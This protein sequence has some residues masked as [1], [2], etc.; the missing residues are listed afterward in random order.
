MTTKNYT[1]DISKVKQLIDLNEKMVN[2]ELSFRVFSTDKSPFEMV[3][4]DQNILDTQQTFDYKHI[5]EGEISGN[6][7]SDKNESRNHYML[8][9]SDKP[10]KVQI[11]IR[12]KE[13]PPNIPV[14]VPSPVISQKHKEGINWLRIIII[15][16]VIL[17]IG[18]VLYTNFSKPKSKE[19]TGFRDTD[20]IFVNSP[21]PKLT[22]PIKIH[23]S[24]SSPVFPK[25]ELLA[26]LKSLKIN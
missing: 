25:N 6:M 20:N 7:I 12:R 8:L 15:S 16:A 19:T 3:I 11:E 9:R 17:G 26:R 14:A 21:P 22:H 2:F 1:L 4:V 23:S 18:Y 13:I 10:C 24:P 5:K